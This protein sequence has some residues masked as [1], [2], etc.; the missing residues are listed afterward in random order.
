MRQSNYSAWTDLVSKI[1]R[2]EV[3]FKNNNSLLLKN[4]VCA[5]K[6]KRRRRMWW[7]SKVMKCKFINT[8]S[9]LWKMETDHLLRTYCITY[10]VQ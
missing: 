8:A 10:R 7:Y 3:V 4:G 1:L 2:R 6:G 9:N 5:F